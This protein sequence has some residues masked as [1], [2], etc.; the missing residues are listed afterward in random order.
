MKVNRLEPLSARQFSR[1][2]FRSLL[3]TKG[4]YPLATRKHPTSYRRQGKL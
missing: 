4:M 1:A 2:L 3:G